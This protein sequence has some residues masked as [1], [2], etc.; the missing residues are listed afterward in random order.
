MLLREYLLLHDRIGQ[1]ARKDNRN[2]VFAQD[3]R[4][5]FQEEIIIGAL[6]GPRDISQAITKS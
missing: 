2:I 3:S 6:N 1:T 4:M 5:S